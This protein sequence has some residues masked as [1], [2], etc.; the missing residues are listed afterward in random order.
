MDTKLKLIL[1]TGSSFLAGIYCH[2]QYNLQKSNLSDP[3]ENYHVVKRPGLPM[4]GTVSAASPVAV[5]SPAL[6]EP[7]VPLLPEKPKDIMV[8]LM[9]NGP[10]EAA[11]TVF[12]DFPNYKSGVY[13]HVSGSALG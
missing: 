13:Q 4:F 5:M 8:E 10:V 3:N 1:A 9:T 2:K 11:F 7:A 12:A 6:T